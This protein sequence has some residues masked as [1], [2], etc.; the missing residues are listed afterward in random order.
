ME[1]KEKPEVPIKP[2]TLSVSEKTRHFEQ[3][4]ATIFVERKPITLRKTETIIEESEARNLIV[5][6]TVETDATVTL[7]CVSDEVFK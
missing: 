5:N 6:S 7:D 1:K 4:A 3:I 2:H